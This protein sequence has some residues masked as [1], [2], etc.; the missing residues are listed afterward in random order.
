M[1]GNITRRGAHSWRLK[2]EAGR[3]PATGKRITK[4]VTVRGAR[5]QAEAELTR[6]TAAQDAGVFIEP[7][8]TTLTAYL[9]GWIA[10]AEALQRITPRTA[11]RYRQIITLQIAPHL[12]ALPL[13]KVGPDQIETW[14]ANSSDQGRRER[15]AISA[16][17]G[18]PS[19]CRA[20]QSATRRGAAPA[21]PAQSRFPHYAAKARR[22][23]DRDFVGRP[24]QT[25]PRRSALDHDLSACRGAARDWIEAR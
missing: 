18:Q 23:R 11:E 4:L 3:D 8:K 21:A 17:H 24:G 2:F 1:R 7:T 9:H 25:G 5:R 22:H 16:P 13:Q 14:H 12:G 15:R 19:P 10:K 20:G 6:L